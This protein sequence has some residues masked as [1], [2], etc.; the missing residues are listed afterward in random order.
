M[1]RLT[2]RPTALVICLFKPKYKNFKKY[3]KNMLSKTKITEKFIVEGEK[4]DVSAISRCLFLGEVDEKQ[5]C[6]LE[7]RAIAR[8]T[9]IKGARCLLSGEEDVER[10]RLNFRAMA[11]VTSNVAQLPQPF[12][13]RRTI[14]DGYGSERMG[15]EW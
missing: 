9:S 7:G 4:F 6:S 10:R 2:D 11:G 5:R 15:P 13:R 8:V 1:R 12:F 3:K 14:M